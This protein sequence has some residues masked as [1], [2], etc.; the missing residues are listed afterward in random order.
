MKKIAIILIL[1]ISCISCNDDFL[2]QQPL[3][4]VSETSVWEDPALI[5]LYV[6]A[7]YN[8]LPHGFTQW[9]GGLR[10]TGLTDESYHMHEPKLDKYTNG[11]VT[12]GN[13]YFYSGFWEE[14]YVGIRNN[15][16]FLEKINPEIGDPTRI[17]QLTAEIR[18]LRAYLYA[19]LIF[20]YG[21][22][23]LIKETFKLDDDFDTDRASFQEC[24]TFI[25]EELDLA[26]PDLLDKESATGDDF[27]RV[28]KGAAIGLK[29]RTLLYAASP[30]FSIVDSQENWEAAAEACE[31]L[32]NLNQYSLSSDYKGMFLNPMDSEIIFFKQFIDE[33]G[34]EVVDTGDGYYHYRGGHNIDEWRFPNGSG[35]W[36]SENPLQNFVDQYETL[37]GE[38]PVLGYT[39]SDNNLQPIL[40][41]NATDYDSANPY[42]NRDPR[43][44]YSIY[45]DGSEF[46]GREIE[47]WEGGKDSDD[48]NVDGFWNA[49]KLG[50]GIRK[51][52][53][54]GVWSSESTTSSAQ[55]WV[56]MR[57][58]EF[59][60]SYAEA[61]YHIGNENLAREYV[62]KTRLR[63][64]VEMPL[65]TSSGI[66]LLNDIKHERKIELAFEGNR[67]YDGRRWKDA[68][69]DFA[70]DVIGVEVL[71]DENTD[72]KT[73]RYFVQK[74]RSFIE[75]HYLWPIPVEEILKTN[76]IQNPGY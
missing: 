6:N 75:S 66:D 51:S 53:D 33:F 40:N 73:Y 39:G 42:L 30:L 44:S 69:A 48:P 5:E 76:L 59:Y 62:N 8:E 4:K 61:Q 21:G 46:A 22:V 14:A 20:R 17:A 24:V 3:D 28:T 45:Y 55:P 60:L 9:A 26:I 12:S 11:E 74:N 2:N 36:V 54:E 58:A 56:Y 47:M 49:S 32:F 1:F 15:T 29:A 71:K 34:P 31:E 63:N 65:I 16:T 68:E 25:K 70:K 18:F 38:I 13:M 52:L 37:L 43:L 7:R 67:W 19:E 64:G 35:G 72:I 41:S 50:Y 23:P 57:L 10:M 27:G